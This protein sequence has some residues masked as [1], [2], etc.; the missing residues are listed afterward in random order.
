MYLRVA[1]GEYRGRKLRTVAGIGT[2]PLLAKVR[3]ALFNIIGPAIQDAEVWDLFAGTG[4][5][6]IEALSRGARRAIFVEKGGSALRVLRENLSELGLDEGEPRRAIL[7]RGN[8]WAPQILDPVTGEP[9]EGEPLPETPP[10][11]VFFDPPYADV[12]E[13][14]TSAVEAV[15]A[16]LDRLAPGGRLMFHFPEGVLDE[17]DL[18]HL[19]VVDLRTWGTTAV[20]FIEGAGTEDHGH[21]R[22][23]QAEPSAPAKPAGDADDSDSEDDEAVGEEE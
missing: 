20:A 10:D 5:N 9:F 12:R 21:V 19:G 14:P 16:L 11:Y 1:G 2:R 17:D 8:A 7:L 6:G 22:V 23:P 3:E 15:A 4:A 18:A 13:D